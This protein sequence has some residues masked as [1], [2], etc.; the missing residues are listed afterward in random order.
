MESATFSIWEQ[1]S[2]LA[3]RDVVIVGGG[4]VG[5]WSAWFLKQQQP[6]LR[7]ALLERGLLPS[8]A[9]S[10]NAGFACFGSPSEITGDIRKMGRDEALQLV[11]MR[12]RGLE[13]TRR[14]FPADVVRFEAC[15][16][17]EC[18]LDGEAYEAT[19]KGLESLNRDLKEITGFYPVFSPKDDLLEQMGLKGFQHLLFNPLEG[20]LHSGALLEALTQML[21]GMG[22][23][24]LTNTEVKGWEEESGGVRVLTSQGFSLSA[25]E[26]LVCTN[27]FA[28]QLLPGADVTPARG[29]VLLTGPIPGLS[30]KGTFHF[31]EGFYYFRHLGE[32]ILLGGA[33]N[34]AV[35][36]ETTTERETT[37]KIQAALE[38]FL[39][40]HV[41]QA[42]GI[43]VTH[44]WA[45]IMGMGAEKRPLIKRVSEHVS[46]AVRLSGVGVAISPLVGEQAAGLV[47]GK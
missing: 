5:M 3:P 30:L 28:G 37:S 26:L 43:P 20:A 6:G 17:S 15:G 12:Y 32:R 45:G 40:E 35:A 23:S 24:I 38:Y 2:Y 36:E 7:V 8:G 19:L 39:G 34:K 16:G 1:E 33:R 9:S 29:Q 18:F 11:E 41:P 47:L 25:R 4:L 22:V 44:R 42:S 13:M 27:G 21:Q 31:D 14:H 46:C 10:R